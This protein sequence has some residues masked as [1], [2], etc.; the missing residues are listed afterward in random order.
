[1]YYSLAVPAM[2]YSIMRLTLL[3][4]SHRLFL[5][6][7]LLIVGIGHTESSALSPS[8]LGTQEIPLPEDWPG[9]AMQRLWLWSGAWLRCTV[10]H[11]SQGSIRLKRL[12]GKAASDW[13]SGAWFAQFTL[14]L[15]NPQMV[16]WSRSR[17]SVFSLTV[18]PV[19]AWAV[20]CVFAAG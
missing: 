4:H 20:K 12:K 10:Y 2:K 13:L 18:L 6:A 5:W 14:Y 3:T 1:M 19:S 7:V 9:L 17:S 11:L 16:P 8:P 15:Q